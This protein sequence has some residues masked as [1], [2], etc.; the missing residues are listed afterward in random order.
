MI[1]DHI[2]HVVRAREPEQER[3]LPGVLLDRALVVPERHVGLV[4]LEEHLA[5]EIHRVLKLKIEF[6]FVS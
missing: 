5:L 1:S 6:V 2:E 3:D 4:Q